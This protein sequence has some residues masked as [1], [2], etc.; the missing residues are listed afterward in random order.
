MEDYEIEDEAVKVKKCSQQGWMYW[1]QRDD[2]WLKMY[3]RL[4]DELL[5]LSKGSDDAIAVIQ[6]AV[7]GVRTTEDGGFIAHGPAGE[8]MELFAYER[9][10][11]SGWIDALFVAA[12]LTESYKRSMVANPSE[13]EISNR[14]SKVN[15]RVYIGTLVIYNKEQGNSSWK[16]LLSTK[17]L[18]GACRQR[19]EKILDRLDTSKR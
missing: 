11:T 6:I 9:N 7:A 4:Y 10:R 1:K 13:T 14:E 18:R 2:C 5:W 12:Q 19:L 17:R 16:Q 8:S 15:E 3:A